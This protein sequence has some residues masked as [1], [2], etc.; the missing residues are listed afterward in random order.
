MRTRPPLAVR[1][2]RLALAALAILVGGVLLVSTQTAWREAPAFLPADQFRP[3]DWTAF[4]GGLSVLALTLVALALAAGWRTVMDWRADDAASAPVAT[5]AFLG[6]SLRIPLPR[7]VID[8][9][10][11]LAFSTTVLTLPVLAVGGPA[12]LFLGLAWTSLTVINLVAGG[13]LGALRR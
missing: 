12:K 11:C 5:G 1:L 8:V 9:V 13:L 6:T 10:I 7:Y 3:S 2:L 4:N